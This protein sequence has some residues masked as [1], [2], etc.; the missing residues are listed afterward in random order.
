MELDYTDELK[1]I[2]SL[3]AD[4]ISKYIFKN[5]VMYNLF[6]EVEY[7]RNIILTN[8]I[9]SDFYKM[10][11]EKG[12]VAIWGTG[13]RTEKFLKFY[14]EVKITCFIDSYK[15][16]QIFH[17]MEVITLEEFIK[18]F[19]DTSIVVLP[20]FS[21]TEIV[22]KIERMGIDRN[23]ILNFA[24]VMEQLY[25]EQY[26]DLPAIKFDVGG[27]VFIDG[28][29]FDGSD[30]IKF[31]KKTGR[32]VQIWEPNQEVISQIMER[33]IEEGISYEL[34][35]AGMSDKKAMVC[36]K[37]TGKKSNFRLDD[38]RNGNILVDSVDNHLKQEVRMIKMDIEGFEYRALLG[39][40]KTIEQYHP[41]L[42]ICV[43]HKKEDIWEIPK[44]IYSMCKRY[45]FYLRHYSLFEYETVLYAIEE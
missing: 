21:Y 34:I 5:R 15:S 1:D 44:L 19:P 42:A 12:P 16:G 31:A 11:C 20:R 25:R 27:G 37:G 10:L 17:G 8:S 26:F 18:L 22:E 9:A 41:I 6:D 40:R 14:P 13:I 29:S 4:E 3:F 30:S 35:Q 45:K 32:G 7:I 33:M 28:G 2:C 23:R 39:A 43:Y 24:L 36:S 38:A